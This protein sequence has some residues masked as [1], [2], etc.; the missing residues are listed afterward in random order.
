MVE[1]I[2]WFVPAGIRSLERLFECSHKPQDLPHAFGVLTAA[3]ERSSLNH[4]N[5]SASGNNT[6]SMAPDGNGISLGAAR[7]PA[8]G[9]QKKTHLPRMPQHTFADAMSITACGWMLFGIPVPEAYSIVNRI[10][11]ASATVSLISWT[12]WSVCPL[13]CAAASHAGRSVIHSLPAHWREEQCRGDAI[14]RGCRDQ[15]R[16]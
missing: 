12:V 7:D 4:S 2:P 3:S 9:H 1:R 11:C 13:G 14:P 15:A 5:T 6:A 10:G 16:A 8:S